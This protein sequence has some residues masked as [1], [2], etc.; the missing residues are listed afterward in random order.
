LDDAIETHEV[1]RND[2]HQSC[3]FVCSVLLAGALFYADRRRAGNSSALN[4]LQF[5][6]GDL[7]SVLPNRGVAMVYWH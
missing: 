3:P 6:L 4:T 2:A 7:A 1:A 5:A